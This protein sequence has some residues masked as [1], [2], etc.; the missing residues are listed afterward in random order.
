MY[1]NTRSCRPAGRPETRLWQRHK[2]CYQPHLTT[3]SGRDG[4][5]DDIQLVQRMH[6]TGI[7]QQLTHRITAATDVR[8]NTSDDSSSYCSPG[9]PFKVLA[10]DMPVSI[11]NISSHH[12]SLALA[13]ACV[14]VAT[15]ARSYLSVASFPLLTRSG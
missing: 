1:R 10:N 8:A 9:T 13:T 12:K 6:I 5:T 7:G 2:K 4:R 11:S 14:A 3:K 15:A